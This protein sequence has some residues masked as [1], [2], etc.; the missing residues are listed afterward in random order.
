MENA[1]PSMCEHPQLGGMCLMHKISHIFA[2]Q[3][4]YVLNRFLFLQR[5]VIMHSYCF[6]M[7]SKSFISKKI[8]S[9]FYLFC[10]K[11][12][13]TK[14]LKSGFHGKSKHFPL[15]RNHAVAQIYP[16]FLLPPH[17]CG[18]KITT[19]VIQDLK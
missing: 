15:L 18:R 11:I 6:H 14:K 5:R 3:D 10:K 12:C 7:E 4:N 17:P 19:K 1:I 2:Q 13:S 16:D 9:F 8:N